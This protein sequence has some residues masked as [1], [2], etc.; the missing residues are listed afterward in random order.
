M[1]LTHVDGSVLTDLGSGGSQMP[2]FCHMSSKTG[3]AKA[4]GAGGCETSGSVAA[5]SGVCDG[6]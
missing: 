2:L 6:R 5:P 4:A 3:R 1:F